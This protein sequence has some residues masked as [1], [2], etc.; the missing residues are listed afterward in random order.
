MP[1]PLPQPTNPHAAVDQELDR[2]SR[3]YDGEEYYYGDEPGPIARRAWRYHR[4]YFRPGV[5]TALDAGCGEGQD[6]AYLAEL[7]YRTTGVEFTPAGAEKSRR[8]VEARGGEAEVIH[9]DLR[10][11]VEGPAQSFDLV[12]AV[13]SV[14]FL[15]ADGPNVLDGLMERVAPGGVIGF[16]LFA[17]EGS[18]SEVSGT[19]WF[20]TLEE[21]LK[22]FQGWQCQEAAKLW[23]WDVRSN[24]PQP[25]VTLIARKV[26]AASGVLR[27]G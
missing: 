3:I 12:L 1:E 8:L 21:L 11:F 10:T 22:R 18:R 4:P 2:W 15:G 20:T 19:I 14:Q 27:L 24:Y 9:T 6:L 16:S 23:Q 13:N 5:S 7:G 25:F 26:P 17:R